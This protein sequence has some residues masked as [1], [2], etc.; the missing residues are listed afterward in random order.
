MD[1]RQDPPS[2]VAGG[3]PEDPRATQL[4]VLNE[5]A[6]IATLDIELRPMLQRITDTLARKLGWEF[7]AL[8][9]VN[10]ERSAFVC[11]ALSSEVA[12][13]VHVGYSR[14][15]GSG[16]VG[17]VAASGEPLVVDDVSVWPNYVETMPGARSELCVPVRHHGRM[18]AILNLESQCLGAFA[19]QLPLLQTVA[20]QVA[21]AIAIA[22]AYG[23]LRAANGRL[24][25]MAAQLEQKSKALEEANRHL[26]TMNET[27]HRIS[28]QDGLTGIANRRHFNEVLLLEMRRAARTGTPVSFLLLDIDFFKAFNDACGHIAGD[29]CL[30][31][32]A[33]SL[34]GALH[35]A[36]DLVSRYGGEE[37]GVLL[38]QTDAH[39]ALHAAEEIRERIESLAIPHP[40][41]P[42]GHITVSI[43]CATVVPPAD[44]SGGELLVHRADQALYE[45]KRAG[46]NRVCEGPQE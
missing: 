35:R 36:S 15:L 5:V 22:Q 6:R 8:V 20:D 7:V 39:G 45:A 9:T 11:E 2:R 37:F 27:L 46:R 17:Q 13:E 3:V 41:S 21:G 40:G 14:P 19:G 26:A 16:V 28:T 1:L 12:T 42:F 10:D 33:S 23:E 30:R 29:E 43:G 38:P 25:E 4:E 18:V 44:G 24:S 32:V 34:A 31:R